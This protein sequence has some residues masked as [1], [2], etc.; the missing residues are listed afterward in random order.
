MAKAVKLSGFDYM[1]GD[2]AS[3]L[4]PA[5]SDA[6][7]EANLVRIKSAPLPL[8]SCTVFI[9]GNLKLTGPEPKT[10]KAIEYAEKA[11]DRAGRAGVS[12][13]VLGS[14]RA[15][16]IPEG[17]DPKKA[18]A[19]FVGFCRKIAPAATRNKVTIVLE[20]LQRK[21]T[22]FINSVAE[23]VEIADEIGHPGIQ[24]IA[25]IFHMVAENESPDS[26]RKA[27]KRL[28]HCHIAERGKRTPP[29]FQGDDFKPFFRA[30]K[31]IHYAGG[32]SIEGG[33]WAKEPDAELSRAHKV[34]T[35]Q[36]STA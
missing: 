24:I 6:E 2:V 28:R 9:P 5:R 23:A 20:A 29:G 26:I 34:L 7:F 4:V 17:F 11:L 33:P 16:F 13:I 8:R 30:L 35:E 18:R 21:E 19:Q 12:F 27:G 32:I 25:D 10:E 1:E 3:L 31:D 22:N 15:R 14:G 36:W